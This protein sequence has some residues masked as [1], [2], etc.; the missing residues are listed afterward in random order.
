M[1]TAKALPHMRMLNY[2]KS[3]SEN[4]QS[5]DSM[6][7]RSLWTHQRS[8]EE[9]RPNLIAI[10][11]KISNQARTY[12]ARVLKLTSQWALRNANSKGTTPHESAQL[13]QE[14]ERKYSICGQHAVS[15]FLNS[16]AQHR[17]NEAEPDSNGNKN[18]QSGPNVPCQSAQTDNFS[19]WALR[20]ANSKGTTPHESAQLLQEQE[21]K[22]SICGQHAVS[23]FVNSSAQHRGNE[24]EPDSNENKNFQSGP[25]VPCQSAQTDQS[26]SSA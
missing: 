16:S 15:F 19:Q 17:G 26:V 13:L 7:F 8:T 3:R 11:I 10:E 1:Q 18:F 2:Y 21:R 25:N 23:F 12:L 22:Y 5:A 14:Q 24:A 6:L 4:T 9:M 20:N